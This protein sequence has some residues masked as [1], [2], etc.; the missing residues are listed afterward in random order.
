MLLPW[1]D[2]PIPP[3][4]RALR[5]NLVLLASEG[6]A[7][8]TAAIDLAAEIAAPSRATVKVLSIARIWG[9]AF[10]MPHPG[11]KPNKS[12]WQAQR[13]IVA[14][15]LDRLSSRGIDAS[16]EVLA[17]RNAVKSILKHARANGA[18]AIVMSAASEPHWTR[19][20]L[21]WSHL[22]HIVARTARLPVYLT[23]ET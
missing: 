1:Q 8:S 2:T 11:L 5:P 17:S 14:A 22:P 16:G 20:G 12:E 19:R 21:L 6:R 3:D 9:S 10:G 4:P 7:I 15:A 13:D 18:G 23:R